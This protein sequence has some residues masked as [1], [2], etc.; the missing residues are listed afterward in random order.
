MFFGICRKEESM[1]VVITGVSSGIGLSLAKVYLSRGHS[2]WGTLRNLKRQPELPTQYRKHVHFIEMDV[3]S[4]SSV[5]KAVAKIRQQTNSRID[6]LVNNAGQMIEGSIEELPLKDTINLFNVNLFGQ[7]RVMQELLPLMRERRSGR[8]VNIASLSALFTIPFSAH[9]SATKAALAQL[10]FALRQELKPFSVQA[11]AVYPG[12]IHTD[13]LKKF[14]DSRKSSGK[15]PYAG[16]YETARLVIQ[17]SIEKGMDKDKL[18]KK[19]YAVS[20]KKN[21]APRY[22]FAMPPMSILPT[23]TRF[24]SKSLEEKISLLYFKIFENRHMPR[25]VIRKDVPIRI[26]RKEFRVHLIDISR[27]GLCFRYYS[28]IPENFT[29]MNFGPVD[30]KVKAVHY[31]VTNRIYGVKFN[32]QIS[33]NQLTALLNSFEKK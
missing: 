11:T 21:M 9:Y 4:D 33:K 3:S 1:N 6:I 25:I 15:S 24:L 23:L 10:T 14:D 20:M 17:Q 18:A 26:D 2:V 8:I 13:L 32:R 12:W 31:E 16:Y 5:K 28:A 27:K 29:R 19:I 7:L 30:L 22:L